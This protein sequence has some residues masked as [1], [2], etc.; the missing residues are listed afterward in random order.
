MPTL[1]TLID[2]EFL[3][4]MPGLAREL[5]QLGAEAR[6]K[7]PL[8]IEESRGVVRED[9][10]RKWRL[11]VHQCTQDA[12]SAGSLDASLRVMKEL[13]AGNTPAQALESINGMDITYHMAGSMAEAVSYFH[14]RGEEFKV[15]CTK[16][17]P[18]LNVGD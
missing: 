13:S 15:Y 5:R 10:W 18:S 17:Y 12:L 3:R 11:Y 6:R 7:E 9:R 8:Y 2:K 4:K 1:N 16:R 14:P